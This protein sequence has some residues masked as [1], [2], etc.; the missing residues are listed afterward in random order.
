[1]DACF[2]G[3]GWVFSHPC[4]LVVV[5]VA[6]GIKLVGV[7]HANQIYFIFTNSQDMFT[8]SVKG[9]GTD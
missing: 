3:T 4:V 8:T 2:I 6:A 1:M 7:Q 5:G 9:S